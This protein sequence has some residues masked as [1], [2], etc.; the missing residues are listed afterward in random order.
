MFQLLEYLHIF[1][2]QFLII[3]PSIFNAESIGIDKV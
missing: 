2:L 1:L 3:F